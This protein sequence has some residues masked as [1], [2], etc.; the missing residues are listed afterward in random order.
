MHL[1]RINDAAIPAY[2]LDAPMQ[3]FGEPYNGPMTF[4]QIV[5]LPGNALS[6]PSPG[7]RLNFIPGS[8]GLGSGVSLNGK[9]MG[10][11]SLIGCR[12]PL[13]EGR[14]PFLI[15]IGFIA[16]KNGEDRLVLMSRTTAGSQDI[17][18]DS[19]QQTGFDVF[20]I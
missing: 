18:C 1:P 19:S 2:S 17:P 8:I 3:L 11:G 4:R 6:L 7:M 5:P 14:K 10:D 16:N 13:L 15:V 20:R 12:S 9:L